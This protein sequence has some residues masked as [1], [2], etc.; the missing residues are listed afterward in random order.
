MTLRTLARGAA[1]ALR[2]ATAAAAALRPGAAA[3]L[4]SATAAAAALRPGAAAALR[5]ATAAAAA[6]R[7]GAAAALRS[8][9]AAA[10]L[11]PGAAAALRSATAAAAAVL[12]P[13][14][15]ALRPGANTL[16]AGAAVALR[17]AAA[18]VAVA[19]RPG[20]AAWRAGAA[21]PW[22]SALAGR[23]ARVAAAGLLLAGLLL[24]AGGGRPG[25]APPAYANQLTVSS[26]A[27][28][29]TPA[30]GDD[31]HAG[32][33]ITIQV[34]FSETITAWGSVTDAALQI[35]IGGTST[36]TIT[37][38]D[39]T[40]HNSAT[41]DFDYVVRST[42]VD[43]DGISVPANPMSG[44]FTHVHPG[45]PHDQASLVFSGLAAD[46]N[47]KVNSTP[48]IDYDTDDDGFIE[49]DSLDKLNAMRH[50][51]TVTGVI[52][53]P[54]G[55][56]AA[57]HAHADAFPRPMPFHGCDANN[58]G[59][60]AACAGYE[61]TA[62]LDFDTDGD[63]DV[64]GDDEY[65]NWEPIRVRATATFDGNEH[66][67]ANLTITSLPATTATSHYAGLFGF[68]RRLDIKNVGLTDV[69]IVISQNIA[70]A[71]GVLYVGGLVADTSLGTEIHNSYTTGTITVTASGSGRTSV[72]GLVGDALYQTYIAACWSS[73]AVT[74]TSTSTDTDPD[75]A[76]G[77]VGR[78]QGITSS[79]E[80]TV[81]A[82]YATGNV[83]SSRASS[84]VGG[85]IGSVVGNG[86]TV[87]ASYSTGAPTS[88]GATPVIGGL[89]G[90][91]GAGATIT[92][93]YWDTTTSAIADDG[94]TNMPEGEPTGDLTGP[95]AYGS[96]SSDIFMSW[97]IDVD[98]ADGNNV[99]TNGTDDPWHFGTAT[100]YPILQFNTGPGIAAQRSPVPTK[101]D[102]DRD[103]DNL[104][105][106][107]SL[108][109]LTAL[110]H[111][112]DSD[113]RSATG[114]AAVGYQK[115]FPGVQA[116]MGCPG[117]CIGYELNADLDFDTSGNGAIAA[118]EYLDPHNNAVTGG[119][120][121]AGWIPIGADTSAAT[122]YTGR[123]E[124]NQRTIKNLFIIINATNTMF[125]GELGLF[126]AVG[127]GGVISGVRMTAGATDA[128]IRVTRSSLADLEVGL[129][130]GVNR[131]TITASSASG[132]VDI[133]EPSP[134]V[135]GLVG[136]NNAN[137]GQGI[138]NASYAAVAVTGAGAQARVGGLV[139]S[140][141]GAINASYATGAV[142]ADGSAAQGG[143]LVGG[144]GSG[145]TISA[146]YSTG[147]VTGANNATVNGLV[148]VN[149][150]PTGISDSYWDSDT[151]GIT[152]TGAGAA[153][154]TAAL[155]G[156][157]DYPTASTATF[158]NWNLN[159]DGVAGGD[160]PWDFGTGGADGDYPLISYASLTPAL[161]GR[162]VIDYDRDDDG[163][164][165][166]RSLAQLDAV[167]YDLDGDGDGLPTHRVAYPNY[168]RGAAGRMGCPAGAC[169]GY[170]VLADLD[171]DTNED[172]NV[173]ASDEYESWT[174]IGD[175]GGAY[176]ANFNGNGH[177]IANLTINLTGSFPTGVTS[178][179]TGLFGYID[180]GPVI[181]NVGLVDVSITD[182]RDPASGSA[183]YYSGALAGRVQGTVRASYATG[184]VTVT[185]GNDT[186]RQAGG[187]IGAVYNVTTTLPSRIVA[188]YAAVSTSM[189]SSSTSSVDDKVGGLLGGIYGSST[190]SPELTASYARGS[191]SGTR[192][193]AQVGGL[194]GRAVNATV[195]AS[196]WD[197]QASGQSTSAGGSGAVAQSASN[198]QT[199]TGYTG[200]YG[201]WNVNVDGDAGTGDDDGNDDP[202]S[203]GANDEYPALKYGGQDLGAQGQPMDYDDNDNGLIDITTLAQLDAIRYDLDGNGG[204]GT[205]NP[206]Y[207]A[208][209]DAFP[210]R[211]RAGATRMGCRRDHDDD[212][213]T[214]LQD[215]CIGYELR[216][217]LD[218]D[219][220]GDGGTYTTGAGGA[221][222]GD[223]DDAYYNGGAGWAPI[224]GHT[225]A[226][227]QFTAIF[228]G[229]GNTI[230]NLYINLDTSGDDDGVYVGLFGIIGTPG[231][232]GAAR[233]VR[234]ADP[235]V[236]NVR[237]STAV[238][239]PATG[240]LAGYSA[241]GSAVS[242]S[243]VT[244]GAVSGEHSATSGGGRVGCLLGLNYG[245]V[246]GSRASCAATS[247]GTSAA[248]SSAE[249]A[250]GLVGQNTR[251]GAT[252]SGIVRDSYAT[253]RV[254][255]EKEAGGLVGNSEINT[256]VTGSYAT[257]RVSTSETAGRAG[258][259]VGATNSGATISDSYATGQVSASGDRSDVGGLAGY[260]SATTVSG[261]YAGGNVS[262]AAAANDSDLGG[263]VGHI[264]LGSTLTGCYATG[265][266]T[267]AGADS[268][269]GGLIGHI[270]HS[271]T[272]PTIRATYATG[273][274]TAS[275]AGTSGNPNNVGGLIGVLD[276]TNSAVS[277]SYARSAVSATGSG[278][279]AGNNTGGLV[280]ALTGSALATQ[281]SN[282]YWDSGI[283]T[284]ASANGGAARTEA[285]LKAPVNY[286]GDY[287][288]GWSTGDPWDFGTDS[289]LPVLIYGAL[290][291]VGQGRTVVDYD[292]DDDGLID[293]RTLAQLDAVRHDLDGDGDPMAAAAA[294]YRAGYP[295]RDGN[296]AG[297]M[298]CQPTDH[299]SN[300]DTPNRATCTGYELRNDLNF[301]TDG[302]GSTHTGGTGDMQD[303]YYNAGMGWEP[304]G[305]T[306]TSANLDQL[307]ATTF[308]GNGFVIDNLFI[309]RTPGNNHSLGMFGEIDSTARIE[310]LGVTNAFVGTNANF[311]GI[312]AGANSGVIIG[313]YVTGKV[314]NLASP[315]GGMVGYINSHIPASG[316][317]V[318]AI[319]ASYSTAEVELTAAS[320][321]T[322]RGLL[323]GSSQGGS[324]SYSYA[325]GRSHG[326]GGQG[327]LVG[328]VVTTGG[329]P[330]AVITES[331]WDRQTT[332]TTGGKTTVELQSPAGY[333]GIYQ[334]W[335]RNLDDDTATGDAQGR[336][337]PWDF[338]FGHYPV[339][340]YG[341]FDVDE[342]RPLRAMVGADVQAYS[343]QP[344]T[345]EGS[346][347]A[348][349]G[350]TLGASPYR[351][352]VADADGVDE[353]A[354][355]LSG[356]ETA[357]VTFPA[358]TGL[359][360][361]KALVLR[362]TVT[363]TVGGRTVT[364]FDEVTVNVVAVRPNQ[365]LSL[366][367]TDSEGDAV[368]LA[369]S[370]ISLTYDYGASVAN[371]I[372][373]VTVT[374]RLLAGSTMTLNGAAVSSGAEVEVPLKYRGNEI[375]I[376]V[377][378]P[379]PDETMNGGGTNGETTDETVEETPCSVENNG[380][381]PC[382][383]TVTVNRAVPPRLAFVPRSLTVDEGG[384]GTYTVELDTRILTGAV[385][386]A[387]ASDN[388][389]VTVSPAEVSFRPLDM[390]PRTITVSAASDA[391]RN[392]EN[393]VLTHTA[394]GAHYYDVIAT[395]GVT[396]NDTTAPPP[397]PEPALSVSA[398]AL[399]L[400][401]GGSGSYTVALA[402]R[403]DDNV[404]VTIASDNADVTTRP[405]A[406]TFT[407]VNWGTAQRVTVRAASDGDTA[408]DTAT[409]T[410]TASGGGYGEAP[411]IQ[412]AV[413]VSDGDTA[414]LAINPTVLNLIENGISAFI[415]SLTAQ[416]SGNVTVSIVSDNPDVTVRPASLAFTPADWAT[417]QA[418]LVITRADDGGG[419]ELAT[420]RMTARGGGYGGQTGQ[421]LASVDDRLVPLPAGA[422]TT[423]PDAPAGVSV[424]GP[425]GTTATATVAAAGADT[426]AVATG[427]GFGI[428]PAVGV[429]VSEA[430]DDGLEICLPVSDALRAEAGSAYTLTL[431]RYAGG[432][433][434]ELDGAR[435]LGDRVCAG[436]VTG[437]AAYAVGYALRPGTVLDLAAAVGAD[438]G[439]IEL[440]W[441]PPAAGTAQVAVVVN[442]A[443]D[444]DY[445]LDT[446]PGLEASSYTC[447]GRTAGATYVALLIVLLPDEGYT[448][449]NIVRF[450]LPAADDTAPAGSQ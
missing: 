262:T 85:L 199:P 239:I 320:A 415:V 400:A 406:L 427:V 182:G 386:V 434:T 33:T 227:A 374:P 4:R 127:S 236:S 414:G 241:A 411:A 34:T 346:G 280:G 344:V 75:I 304:I 390:A 331:Y 249:Y 115:A 385:T 248:F 26:M 420:L 310:T 436:G 223:D 407:T 287:G 126:G 140:N 450:E 172:G 402:T 404:T 129:L 90:N 30:E 359:T 145:S 398:T 401:E 328:N 273:A 225:S 174:P 437:E 105:D 67:I 361:D 18:A 268:N 139:G 329:I 162:A 439:T 188:S 324:I 421:V 321:I 1:A 13:A 254:I 156:A 211:E 281:V 2:S 228:D 16:R 78:V 256:T 43:S 394:N 297:R 365:L 382:T 209:N 80:S 10:A 426:P 221:V 69:N 36:H 292:D 247:T 276:G 389:D 291:A 260:V 259:L 157:T 306:S 408:A 224:G 339:L 96:T 405:A 147:T 102:Y 251:S 285:Q 88:S 212:P 279:S 314:Q 352:T 131:G 244:G 170:E 177:T 5:S 362:L 83:S 245:V 349:A 311:I 175:A 133:T 89:I 336:D 181:E 395:V 56:F 338:R 112:L 282:S 61:L 332:G 235:Y 3:A 46:M 322:T 17:S 118:D 203:F 272:A 348:L 347:Q 381:K 330:A 72:G 327:E 95:T 208:Y 14:T 49:I 141:L 354:L 215:G 48:T 58:D 143:G 263:L 178:N 266:V 313:C 144:N 353:S 137:N 51:R 378:P 384:T 110:R 74:L 258:G 37:L 121:W 284:T 270:A 271:G 430:P 128:R 442:V 243:W 29:S 205:G 82:A 296:L 155:K 210:H 22:R 298:G 206:A 183:S 448:L 138:I 366:A 333:T 173:D 7:P 35:G 372:S 380:V 412:V 142:T 47:H 377:T 111:D 149:S 312:L 342:Q 94:D 176:T 99:L 325:I 445:C 25:G 318:G 50:N 343:G 146:C 409:L 153:K 387:I 417:P 15:A 202:W 216:A 71:N 81:L 383:Y 6:L 100:D 171:F 109:E 191:V 187:L 444:T 413:S 136:A 399:R 351:W 166:I 93:S 179:Y 363:G 103:D 192:T 234:L 337:D 57:D 370:F 307:F 237:N 278:G 376:V 345:L 443:D 393:V 317:S 158:Y 20:V 186:N 200:I 373:S 164:I 218:F 97:N 367:L 315:A 425:P 368:G 446:L 222:T 403:P 54:T 195:T 418:V 423:G 391:D 130:A 369:P 55:Q 255:G 135:G 32:E 41:V 116:G 240:A 168:E 396:V 435:D 152:G 120:G 335:N 68:T 151:T 432:V 232:A 167:R 300:A 86:I 250:G 267:A 231:D 108:L 233:N 438:P 286:T 220:D 59:T 150:N 91:I 308:R 334:N 375:V 73:V 229:N 63:G 64:D 122:R 301:D 23:G 355:V 416:P 319:I 161:Q 226:A 125:P 252:N 197:T 148:G 194:L 238:R 77:L 388:A 302:D 70:N 114:A 193:G 274:V 52:G 217:S 419:D 204:T 265:T 303:D 275:G 180:G 106:I 92:A 219:T 31:Y 242:G 39:K 119:G 184:S 440:S 163:L 253:G 356:A 269:A 261:C 98:N 316:P 198:L 79:N 65:P 134:N 107:T 428:G 309:N 323:V 424:Y 196:Y 165:D 213:D 19:L 371:Q 8:A 277:A 410:H 283:Y 207:T 60:P 246:S 12:R 326:A 76:G 299:D 159:L 42:D 44:N 214:A 290:T 257:G 397:E 357:R 24:V 132:V 101:V 392:D 360:E 38:E 449:A 45:T 117:A 185:V 190:L 160:D 201:S 289:E 294:D 66:T 293:I 124:G 447:A 429:A 295:N 113:G 154:T 104:I 27:I 53:N 230:D 422:V 441:T 341:N 169:T 350:A 28:T 189:D 305:S 340:K 431:L 288:T 62:D 379:E 433:W 9:T 87:A 21:L 40:G 123:F 11:R 364:V 84:Q 358:P 264:R